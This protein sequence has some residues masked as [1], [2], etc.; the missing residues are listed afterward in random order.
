MKEFKM[1]ACP[2]AA[3]DIFLKNGQHVKF[4]SETLAHY[5]VELCFS[6]KQRAITHHF[7]RIQG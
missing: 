5:S 1:S 2:L 6:R 7:M 3:S 4:L